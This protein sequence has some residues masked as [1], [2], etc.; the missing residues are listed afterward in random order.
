MRV[1][2]EK[3][4]AFAAKEKISILPARLVVGREDTVNREFSTDRDIERKDAFDDAAL[5][6][7][8]SS[9]LQIIAWIRNH[10]KYLCH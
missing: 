7:E 10:K 9:P 8:D 6:P 1:S 5:F 3:L 4:L 2:Y